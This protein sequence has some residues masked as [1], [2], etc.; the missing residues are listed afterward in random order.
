MPFFRKKP[1]VI[2]ARQVASYMD[3]PRVTEWVEA[4]GGK[5]TYGQTDPGPAEGY[6]ST[7]EGLLHVSVG[8]F[9]VKGTKNEFYPVKPDIFCDIYEPV[10]T[11]K[12]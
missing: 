5:M 2:E 9:V 7:L 4:N 3:L 8:D 1:V 6:I 12:A 10:D 11:E